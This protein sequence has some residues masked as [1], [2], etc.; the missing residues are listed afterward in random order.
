MS[1]SFMSTDMA[2]VQTPGGPG[3][4]STFW[5]QV[6]VLMS[7]KILRSPTLMGSVVENGE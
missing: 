6:A 3:L 1:A 2:H 5:L 4:E 7:G